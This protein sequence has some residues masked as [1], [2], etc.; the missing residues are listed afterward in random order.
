MPSLHGSGA[1]APSGQ[2]EPGSQATH[3]VAS[4]YSNTLGYKADAM[5]AL[6]RRYAATPFTGF[7]FAAPPRARSRSPVPDELERPAVRQ[8]RRR[9]SGGAAAAAALASG[10]ARLARS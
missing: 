1:D 9:P 10:R 5:D 3:K 4:P 7:D 6:L 8:R 2:Y